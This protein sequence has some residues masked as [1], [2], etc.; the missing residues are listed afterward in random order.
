MYKAFYALNKDPFSKDFIAS[1][2]FSY[3][4]LKEAVIR[5][6]YL[7]KAKGIGLI[8]GEPGIGK[9]TVLR[10]FANSLEP[11]LFRVMYTPM[12]SG[13]VMD[14]YR[15]LAFCLGEQPRFRKVDIFHQ[16]QDACNDL[17][18]KRGI[19]P[20]F[21]LDEMQ[22][23]KPSFLNDLNLIFNFNMDAKLPFILILSGLPHLATKLS[24]NLNRSLDSRIIMRYEMEPMSKEDVTNFIK[25]RLEHA[26]V[27][28]S[29]FTDNALTAISS[30]S[31]GMPRFVC[32]I[33]THAL[34]QGASSSAQVIDEEIIRSAALEAGL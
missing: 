30:I 28:R 9:T 18:S 32:N 26:G 14:F 25:T 24:L 19:T 31:R 17:Y 15:E 10:Y 33:C 11:A 12:S 23:A 1:N 29:I 16:V 8:T 7:K 34:I 21:I 20:V 2:A 4:V 6:D 22:A 5:L 27:T 13:T 3:D